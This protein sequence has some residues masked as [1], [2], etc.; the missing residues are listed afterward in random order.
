[1]ADHILR[2]RKDDNTVVDIA[3]TDPDNNVAVRAHDSTTFETLRRRFGATS[4]L[5][6]KVTTSGETV[7]VSP[8]AGNAVR[9]RWLYAATSENN[10]QEVEVTVRLGGTVIYTFPLG[11]PGIFAHSSVRDGA[12]DADL[13]VTLNVAAPV[14]INLEYEEV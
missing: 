1:M 2:V 9:L 10:G 4:G 7:L 3:V 11:A 8:A 12:V 13:T 6:Q 5:A 14:Y